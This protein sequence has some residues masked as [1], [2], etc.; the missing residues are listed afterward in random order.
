[1]TTSEYVF[2]T[3]NVQSLAPTD[4]LYVPLTHAV[5]GSPD[6]YP[7]TEISVSSK[8]KVVV[9]CSKYRY[10]PRL[11][12]VYTCHGLVQFGTGEHSAFEVYGL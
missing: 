1:L 10:C 9:G 4:G 2:S 12:H 7:D 11:S 8:F 3:H 5:Q 6:V